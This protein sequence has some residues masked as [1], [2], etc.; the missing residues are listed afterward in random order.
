[1]DTSLH[2]HI[3]LPTERLLSGSEKIVIVD[4]DPMIRQILLAFFAQ[5]GLTAQAAAGGAEMERLL[6]RTCALVVL[7]LGL[8]DVSGL[9]LLPGIITNHP[10][11]A[12][13]ILTGQQ[14]ITTAVSCMRQGADDY[15]LKP[16]QLEE[17]G[18]VVRRVLARRRL[19]FESRTYQ[20]ELEK[21]Q[22]HIQLLHQLSAKMNSAYLSA[23]EMS[24]VLTTIL[25]GITAAEGLRFNRAFLA[26]F[27]E[28]T[29]ELRG[30]TAIGPSCR[31]E[32]G[33]V[34][35]EMRERNFTLLDIIK[36]AK[37]CGAE[38]DSELSRRIHALSIPVSRADNLLI[39][40]LLEKKSFIV[41]NSA[42]QYGP[43][44]EELTALVGNA[45]FTVVPLFAPNRPLGVI[46]ADNFITGNPITRGQVHALEIFASQA[47]LVMEHHRLRRDMRDK[48]HSLEQLT[49]ELDRKKDLLVEAERYAALGQM[50]GQ[51]MHAIR[52]PL[53]AIGGMARIVK[54]KSAASPLN[55]Y[56]DVILKEAAR[57]EAT[58]NDLVDF[59]DHSDPRKEPVMLTSLLHEALLLLKTSID[60]KN[61]VCDARLPEPGPEIN[62]DPRQMQLLVV[63]LVKN[64]LE[65]MDGGGVLTV[66]L[67]EQE[68]LVRIAIRDT[69]PG[70]VGG[71]LEQ[72]RTPFFTTKTQGTGIGLSI[73][74]RIAQ[75]HNGS[76][77]LAPLSAGGMEALVTLPR[78]G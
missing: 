39:K 9:E 44:P 15:L 17:L 37:S 26:L 50:A 23:S 11:T 18:I 53:T 78:A 20:E 14:D 65:A 54:G 27:H 61:V 72:S 77:E 34:W 48:I 45:S 24:D 75:A 68:Q 41:D 42:E 63:H 57:L 8:P 62:A 73:V 40:S 38:G 19:Y 5:Q 64:A 30:E 43:I 59:T 6:D 2:Q 12:V 47:S 76:F 60:A 36:N 58:L 71:Q 69:G 31:E 56:L 46:I 28:E 70:M 16:M 1:M 67:Q 13:I 25:I 35:A 29:G 74:T 4:D 49:L 21:A 32:A 33:R 10:D 7:D 55:V 22:F 52:N 51:M 66:E 3:S